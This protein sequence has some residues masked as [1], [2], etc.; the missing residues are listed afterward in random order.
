V[1]CAINRGANKQP[2]QATNQ[3]IIKFKRAESVAV[4]QFNL[5]LNKSADELTLPD[6]PPPPHAHKHPTTSRPNGRN[7]RILIYLQYRRYALT[8]QLLGTD[9][10][11]TPQFVLELSSLMTIDPTEDLWI[12]RRCRAVRDAMGPVLGQAMLSRCRLQSGRADLQ[13]HQHFRFVVLL[14][15]TPQRRQRLLDACITYARER[16]REQ[17]T[18]NKTDNVPLIKIH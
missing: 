14:V 10:S 15:I 1:H 3:T 17:K 4:C 16:E 9:H 12:E 11:M 5:H 2:R 18:I 7:C 8:V 6:S 13:A